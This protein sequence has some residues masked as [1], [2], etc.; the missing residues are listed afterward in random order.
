LCI[1]GRNTH[2]LL[3]LALLVTC[4]LLQLATPVWCWKYSALVTQMLLE[5]ALF[6]H[7]YAT[8]KY[9]AYVLPKKELLL[10]FVMF[11]TSYWWHVPWPLVKFLLVTIQSFPMYCRYVIIRQFSDSY[12]RQFSN[13]C[14]VSVVFHGNGNAIHTRGDAW[15]VFCV[16][17]A[18]LNL[19]TRSDYVN[20]CKKKTTSFKNRL[21]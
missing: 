6:A 9:L 17:F 14:L 12:N 18:N 21:L 16:T 10:T 15:L 19:Q 20:G 11:E 5:Q 1:C 13:S 8:R 4:M 3:N 2:M 7:S